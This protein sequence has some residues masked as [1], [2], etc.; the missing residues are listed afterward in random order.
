[1]LVDPSWNVTIVDNCTL[2]EADHLLREGVEHPWASW[3]AYRLVA[4]SG[5]DDPSRR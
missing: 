3:S 1:M 2:D 4:S 5:W